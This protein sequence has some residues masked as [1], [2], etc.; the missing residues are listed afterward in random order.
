MIIGS[1]LSKWINDY[2]FLERKNNWFKIISYHFFKKRS[3]KKNTFK[4]K[5]KI[6]TDE[7]YNST[8]TWQRNWSEKKAYECK[9]PPSHKPTPDIF[10]IITSNQK[11]MFFFSITSHQT[12]NLVFCSCRCAKFKYAYE[13]LICT[14]SVSV[15]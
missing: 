5:S 15:N 10:Q 14:I 9:Y 1:F 4:C 6:L 8:S 11:N 2:D 3:F 12:R 13:M 7:Y